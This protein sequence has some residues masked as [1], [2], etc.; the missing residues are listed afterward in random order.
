MVQI[1]YDGGFTSEEETIKKE[2]GI[3][4]FVMW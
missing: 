4:I 2:G 3:H 1:V